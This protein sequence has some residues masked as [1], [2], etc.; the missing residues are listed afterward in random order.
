M[1]LLGQNIKQ[2]VKI[3]CRFCRRYA[4][5]A[6]IAI[7]FL[8]ACLLLSVIFLV[9]LM[10]G[11]APIADKV[12]FGV[13]FSEPFAKQL[14]LDWQAAYLALLDD[15]HVRK[16]RLIAYWP[17]IEKEAGNYVFDDL[18][19]QIKEARKRKAEVIL[20]IGR[21]TPRWPEC[22]IP[23]WAKGLSKDAQQEKVLA[24]LNQIVEHYKD[25][26]AIKYWQV[27]NE[28]F[29]NSFGECPKLDKKFLDKEIA[30]VKSL[31]ARPIILTDSGE[32]SS[33]LGPMRRTKIL[34][35]TLYRVVWSETLG[36]FRYPLPPVFYYKRARLAEELFGLE[37]VLVIELQAEPWGPKQIYETPITQQE[38]SMNLTEFKKTVEYMRQTGLEE[39]YLWGV[40]WWYWMKTTIGD[41]GIWNEAKKLWP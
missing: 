13:T 11:R 26:P 38:Q 24:L 36:Y 21:K 33:W 32:L 35:T 10:I 5:P 14:G 30:L 39:A 25:N 37:K 20:A 19:W 12:D 29:F 16:L 28:P 22:H 40:E 6:R 9:Y 17:E 3:I 4:H 7:L 18:D 31:D 2:R 15:L 8:M 1:S 23:E 34:G 27:E 41:P